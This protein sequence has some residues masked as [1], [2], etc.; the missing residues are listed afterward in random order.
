M[1]EELNVIRKHLLDCYGLD[2]NEAKCYFSTQ[3]Y[4]FIF[5]DKPNMIRVSIG[6]GKSREE[7]LSE[8][9]WVDDLKQFSETVC[10]PFPSLKNHIIEEFELDGVHYRAA[11]FRTAKGNVRDISKMDPMYFIAVGDFLGRIHA[12]SADAASQG[13]TYKRKKWYDKRE[14]TIE[15]ARKVLSSEMMERIGQ[16]YSRV[17]EVPED[18]RWFGMIHGDFHTNNFFVDGN[19][20]W[21]FDFDECCY[22]YFMYD[23][24]SALITWL[25]YGY[26][27]DQKKTRRQA[28]YEDILPYFKIGYGLHLN[29]PEEHWDTLELFL[30]DRCC[31]M[32]LAL[33]QIQKSGILKD[34]DATRQF[35]CFPL[36]QKDILD[37]FDTILKQAGAFQSGFGTPDS[38]D[39]QGAADAIQSP[40]GQTTLPLGKR[41]DAATAP[42]LEKQVM[43]LKDNGCLNLI[44]DCSALEYI[45]SAGL[46]VLLK[47]LKSFDSL[48]LVNISPEV[49]EIL[50]MTGLMELMEK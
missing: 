43:E 4:A 38:E 23:I 30:E 45:S 44:M 7:T 47:A 24:A 41:L 10:E 28:L 17:K 1:N 3:N 35:V 27:M 9:L 42:Q 39:S 11:M 15:N 14:I 5:P 34:L 2:I 33:S 37:G 12:A 40:A 20:I 8:V 29:L 25:M 16:I 19:N 36:T 6:K 48:N 13:I 50:E 21:A 26:G 31:V 46:R 18:P 32:A 49:R 22:G